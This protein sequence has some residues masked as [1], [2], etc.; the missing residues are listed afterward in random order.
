MK[1]SPSGSFPGTQ[2]RHRATFS[3]NSS[4]SS[5][6]SSS[7]G[8]LIEASGQC[9]GRSSLNTQSHRGNAVTQVDDSTHSIWES[10]L[11]APIQI[12]MQQT[13]VL[14]EDVVH[15]RYLTVYNR[16]VKFSHTEEAASSNN[17][18]EVSMVAQFLGLLDDPAAAVAELLSC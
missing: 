11:S 17:L 10:E 9:A 14:T 13:E 18:P 15:Q 2:A 12:P 16:R 6:R 1:C 7:S 5:R 4:Q 3:R 8:H